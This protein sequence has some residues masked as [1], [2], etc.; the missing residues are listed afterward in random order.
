MSNKRTEE[1]LKFDREHIVHSKWAMGGNCGIVI[2]KGYGIYFEDTEGKKYI[3]GSSQLVCVNLG[4]GQQEIVDAV[5]A[6]M[7]QI[8][9]AMHFYGF[10]NEPSIRCAEK[11]SEIVPKG[12]THFNFTTGGSQS[13]DIAI[14]LVR[15]YWHAKGKAKYKIISL[16]DSYHG[17]GGSGLASAGSG[18][19]FFEKGAVPLMPGFVHIPSFY[20]YRC[21]FGLEYPSCDMRCARFL[22]EVIEKE[23]ADNI[24]AFIA[25]PVIGAGGMIP[26]PPEYWPL[27]REICNKYNVLLIDDEVMTGFGRTGKM[28]AVEH[29]N[30]TPD[31]MTMAK[32]LTSAYMPFGAIAFSDEIW[33]TLQGS[34]FITFTYAGHPACAAAAVKA[35]EIYERDKV[36]GNAARVGKY[37]V[38][39]LK[40]VLGPLPSVA[41]ISGLG[42][43]IGI[44][45]VADKT[46]KRPFDQKL[47]VMQRLHEKALANGLYIRVSDI[48][49][50][51]GDR[52][53]FCPPLVITTEEVDKMIGIL[54]PIVASLH[55][56][57]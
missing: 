21:M 9:C 32:G 12:L 7:E 28:F 16:Y 39:R 45:I 23:G 47:K 41:E 46:T 29:W 6:Q 31:I 10:A 26:P 42:L 2:D 24:A 13:V 56:T 20:C 49:G 34:N 5:K 54:Q 48:G 11:L 15:L 43:M 44:E 50:G 27:I 19:G 14:R 4:Y 51:P 1:L 3:D 37:A 22:G 18:R 36:V 30:V 17:V 40:E 52:A 55:Q 33:N 25:E 8:P 57:T 38:G 53:A 35:L